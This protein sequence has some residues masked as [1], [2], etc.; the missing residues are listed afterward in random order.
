M[1]QH[2]TA[3]EIVRSKEILVSTSRHIIRT[4][5]EMRGCSPAY[6]QS[7][8]TKLT[9]V[10]SDDSE[11]LRVLA[12]F[13]GKQFS[14]YNCETATESTKIKFSEEALQTALA[15]FLVHASSDITD[16]DDHEV[17][18]LLRSAL[19]ILTDQLSAIHEQQRREIADILYPLAQT[20]PTA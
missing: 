12:V 20:K 16:D 5:L 19:R 9:A 17:Q 3:V 4:A 15:L 18:F 10:V 1:N 8:G 6:G 11:A 13:L 7:L 2:K 14:Y